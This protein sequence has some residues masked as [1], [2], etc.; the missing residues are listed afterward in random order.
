LYL[1]LN[2]TLLLYLSI[3]LFC[4][5]LYTRKIRYLW[6]VCVVLLVIS[7]EGSVSLILQSREK[8]TILYS[9]REN[10]LIDKIDGL[11]AQLSSLDTVVNLGSV[12]YQVEPNRLSNHLP[13]V[14]RVELLKSTHR[15][16]YDFACL[17]VHDRMRYLHVFKSLPNEHIRFTLDTDYLIVANNSF[18][19]FNDIS[20]YIQFKYLIIDPSNSRKIKN[21]LKREANKNGIQ[22][23]LLD[24]QSLIVSGN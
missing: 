13:P 4:A 20:D 14:E 5:F 21:E 18:K 10:Q 11:H 8:Q 19:T 24:E 3:V 15:L 1:S 23:I 2:Q 6:S 7:V 22:A 9:T 12:K 16:I 17:N